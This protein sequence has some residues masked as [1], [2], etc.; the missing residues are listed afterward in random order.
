MYLHS[1]GVVHRDIKP[2]NIMVQITGN[3]KTIVITDFDACA[4]KIS[5]NETIFGTVGFMG[6]ELF[7]GK[8]YDYRCDTFSLGKTM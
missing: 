7:E 3:V 8:P 4:F 2:D 6:S 1:Q 5:S